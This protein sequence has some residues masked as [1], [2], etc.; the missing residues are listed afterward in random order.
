MADS[1]ESLSLTGSERLEKVATDLKMGEPS[2]VLTVRGFL[3]WF[4]A[5]R[6]GYYVVRGIRASL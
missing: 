1:F 6:R 4:G 3:A 5:M 2:P